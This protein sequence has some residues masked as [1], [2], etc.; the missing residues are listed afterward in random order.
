MPDSGMTLVFDGH[1]DLLLRLF[2]RGGA[3]AAR[4]FLEG[5]GQGHL[6][7]PRMKQGGM[8]GGFFA[9]F[10]PNIERSD[11]EALYAG[12]SY[13]I[14]L[15][16]SVPCDVAQAVTLNQVSKLFSIERE[17]GGQF[18]VVR[19]A[20]EID[21][22][23]A[24]GIV[25]AIMHIEGAEAIDPDFHMLE[26]LY[27]AGLR[28]IGPVWSRANIFGNGVPFRFPSTGD[29]GDGLTEHGIRLVRECNARRI[30]IDLS[31]LNEKGFWDVARL[32]DAPLIAT[33]SNAH[34]IS[35]TSRNLTDKQLA[36]IRETAGLVGVSYIRSAI[37]R[38]GRVGVD[39]SLD[40][41]IDH[42]AYLVDKLGDDKVGMGSD[43]DGA[44]APSGI[45]CAAG[46]QNLVGAM[47]RRGFD[48][49]TLNKICH[50]NWIRVL[51]RT[52]GG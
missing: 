35:Q 38:D 11:N 12:E 2:E 19:S 45:G 50:G 3:D 7:M 31:H 1:N 16:P 47:R 23:I 29:I 43:F 14:P 15:P 39:A 22:C 37:R 9:M 30:M 42:I 51:S 32:S 44:T 21:R 24:N 36:A 18:K 10:V 49:P 4:S 27:Q 48:E 33:H 17:S 52:W 13:D 41:L 20:A 40:M 26:V 34:A 25:A 28:S 5:G 6:D 46:L 8:A